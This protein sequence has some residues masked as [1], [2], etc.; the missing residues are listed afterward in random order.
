MLPFYFRI[1]DFARTKVTGFG[2]CVFRIFISVILLVEVGKL[3][4]FRHLYFDPI[5]YLVESQLS[6]SLVLVAWMGV[7]V[8]GL[9]IGFKTRAAALINYVLVLV[10]FSSLT[11]LKYHFDAAL[12]GVS[13]MLL[14]LPVNTRLSIDS[15]IYK[16]RVMNEQEQKVRKIYYYLPVLLVLCLQYFD[17]FFHK[18]VSTSWIKGLGVWLPASLPDQVYTNQSW[19]LNQKEIILALGYL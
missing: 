9:L 3:F 1:E 16:F 17:S 7:L 8:F 12:I 18:S 19:L 5:P 4:Y 11:S 15:L 14:L 13:F 2:L 6:F 10:F